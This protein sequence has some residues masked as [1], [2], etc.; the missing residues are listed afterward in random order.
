MRPWG[1][2]QRFVSRGKVNW[3]KV[4]NCRAARMIRK[5]MLEREYCTC[6]RCCPVNLETHKEID[7]LMDHEG[8][9]ER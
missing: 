1:S 7:D 3:D 5:K 8:I 2:L 4:F 9:S 6:D